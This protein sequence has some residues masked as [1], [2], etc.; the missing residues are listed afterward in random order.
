[1]RELSLNFDSVHFASFE[2]IVSCI[3]SINAT[4]IKFV[5]LTFGSL[6]LLAT[7]FR[8]VTGALLDL[9]KQSKG[10]IQIELLARRQ[11]KE[12][13]SVLERLI[14][15]ISWEFRIGIADPRGEEL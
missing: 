3:Q 12:S 4:S 2:S 15:G 9:R 11:P 8:Q 13:M 6:F 1:M 10:L 7:H 14:K 5:S